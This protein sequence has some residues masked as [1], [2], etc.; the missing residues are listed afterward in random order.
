MRK[1]VSIL[2]VIMLIATMTTT[3]FTPLRATDSTAKL[4]LSTAKT[5]FAYGEDIVVDITGYTDELSAVDMEL[6]LEKGIVQQW[7]GYNDRTSYGYKAYLDIGVDARDENANPISTP[8]ST[9]RVTFKNG[10]R[11]HPE[12]ANLGTADI[13]EGYYTLW[14]LGFTNGYRD[15]LSNRIY[16]TVGTVPTLSLSKTVYTT[17]ENIVATYANF[18]SAYY[19]SSFT[20]IDIFSD[21]AIPGQVA[22]KAGYVVNNSS[23][24]GIPASGTITFPAD[25]TDRNG[26]NFPL[27]PGNYYIC[28]R[29]D[30]KIVGVPVYFKIVTP[31]P[32]EISVSKEVYTAGEDIVI[33]YK[34]FMEEYWGTHYSEIDIFAKGN[35]I[36]VN[37]CLAYATVSTGTDKVRETNG[38][39]TFPADDERN[40]VNF[41]LLP[42]EYYAC[43]RADNSIVG[44][45]VE[46]TVK[47]KVVTEISVPVAEITEGE[48]LTVNYTGI[49]S[50]LG[51]D[52]EIRVYEKGKDTVGVD[53]SV[54]YCDLIDDDG[55]LLVES[56]D[57]S[58]V[59]PKDDA[60]GN[61]AIPAG[62]YVVKLIGAQNKQIGD[63]VEFTVK[64]KVPIV[65]EVEK[66]TIAEGDELVINY[67]GID[68]RLGTDVEFR[69]YRAGEETPGVNASIMYF[70]LINEDGS[71]VRGTS[72]T[73][74]FPLDDARGNTLLSAGEYRLK[75]IGGQNKQLGDTI[76]ITVKSAVEFSVV[77]TKIDDGESIEI[78]YSGISE[79]AGKNLEL[80]LYKSGEETP[81]VDRSVMYFTLT[82]N[83]AAPANGSSGTIVFPR[84]DARGS[85]ELPTGVYKLKLIDGTNR[86]IGDSITVIVGEPEINVT[87]GDS[88]LWILACA[89]MLIVCALVTVGKRVKKN[90]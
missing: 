16:I 67:S 5:S 80:R 60:R 53:R 36:G 73:V 24:S 76:N 8:T 38:T 26:V 65:V 47:A 48:D 75:L 66:N 85:T 43:M 44:D 33:T 25:D 41:P 19:G 18:T 68:S 23:V 2:L 82:D 51:K 6:R 12:A 78:N 31:N 4:T 79:S 13:T 20:E 70:K 11:V 29:A 40:S 77:N 52:V 55:N 57:G 86:Q 35:V 56:S 32:P 46:F 54:M 58:V 72:G 28:L 88:E 49:V 87:T 15:V 1:K 59:F 21:G 10:M 9:H 45:P 61:T 7:H 42:G 30:N 3:F 34:N 22:S 39:V 64:A 63:G 50:D 81:G 84:D 27:T 74:K 62:N 17:G 37:P 83:N 69:L 71:T 90:I 14:V 89:A